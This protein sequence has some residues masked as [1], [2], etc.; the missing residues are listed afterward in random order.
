MAFKDSDNFTS[1]ST[2]DSKMTKRRSYNELGI[3]GQDCTPG[4]EAALM[5]HA[6]Q[7]Q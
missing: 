3:M 1:N 2:Q 6:C 7:I 5:K 4:D